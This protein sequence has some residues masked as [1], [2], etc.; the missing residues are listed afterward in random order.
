VSNDAAE[1]I[2]KIKEIGLVKKVVKLPPLSI[3]ALLMLASA[4]GPSIR[5]STIGPSG[6]S[7]SLKRKPNTPDRNTIMRSNALLFMA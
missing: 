5:A 4:I 6:T 2:N 3:S 7:R 1:R